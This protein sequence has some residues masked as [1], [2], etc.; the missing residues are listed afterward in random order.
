MQY[1][2]ANVVLRYLLNDQPEQSPAARTIIGT[3]QVELTVEVLAE[4]VYA[5]E[6][7]YEVPR[8]VIADQ[9]NA[10]LDDSGLIVVNRDMVIAALNIYGAEELDFV[11]CVLAARALTGD[12]EVHTF[13]RNLRRFLDGAS[14]AY[15]Q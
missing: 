1:A 14:S 7:V 6:G 5:L 10:C 13:N 15:E 4:V 9:L 2:D 8:A 11:D 3:G 12:A